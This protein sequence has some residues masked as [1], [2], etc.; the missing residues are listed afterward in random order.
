VSAASVCHVAW[1]QVLA[2]VSGRDDVVFGTVLFGRMQGGEGAD[3][4]MGPFINTLPVRVRVGGEGAEASVRRGAR[5]AGELLRHEHASLALAQRCSGVRAPAPL[6]TALLNYRHAGRRRP[7]ADGPGR[8]DAGDLRR[9]AD[10]LPA[11]L[12]VDD[13]GDGFR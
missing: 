5:A 4:V 13:L 7:R 6:F 8:R 12:S 10:Q 3:R 1:A 9:G 11:H 2:R